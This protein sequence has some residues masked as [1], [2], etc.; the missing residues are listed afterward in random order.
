[1]EPNLPINE[2]NATYDPNNPFARILRGEAPCIKV[3]EDDTALA[4]MDVMP[5][6]DGH[7][8][9]IAKETAIDIFGLSD[10]ATAAC[11]RMVRQ[12][13]TAQRAALGADGIIITQLN[14][15]AAGQTVGH[16]HFHVI[17]C[18]A[19]LSLRPHAHKTAEQATLEF[20]AKLIKAQWPT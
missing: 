15:R 16:I 17:P 3:Y 19:G 8:L 6:A 18:R 2:R 7:M 14:G 5:Q 9:V 13:A 10:E 11:M 4:I 12:A 1:M 20:F